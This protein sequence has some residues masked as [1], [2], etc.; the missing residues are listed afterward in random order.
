MDDLYQ[1]QIL[2]HWRHSPHRGSLDAPDAAAEGMNPLCG[3][4]VRIELRL[5]EG[6]V[7]AMKFAGQG[8]VISQAAA[9]MLADLVEGRGV[10][11][12]RDLDRQELLAELGIP[13]SPARLKCALLPLAV[14]RQALE[15]SGS[16]RHE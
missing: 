5:R 2:D 7:E 4:A 13:L 9:S 6:R 10:D 16:A 11:E 15:T 1:E 8:C 12:A 3:D 14:L